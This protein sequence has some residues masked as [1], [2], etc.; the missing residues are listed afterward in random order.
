MSQRP[1]VEQY[2]NKFPE[3]EKCLG[4]E[5]DSNV[6]YMNSVMQVLYR[7]KPFRDQVLRW[8][9]SNKEK[10]YLINEVHD[11]FKSMSS[12]KGNRGIVNHRRFI[13]RIRA[14]NA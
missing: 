4:L 2:L 14:G 1:Q 11:F 13:A 3:E 6:C 7:C 12:A 9:P 8:R 10:Y 5:N